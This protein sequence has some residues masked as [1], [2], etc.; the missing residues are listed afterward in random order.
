MRKQRAPL[1]D[2]FDRVGPFHPYLV[3]IGVAILDI[4][5]IAAA[6]ALLAMLGDAVEDAIWP[7]GFDVIQAL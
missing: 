5:I 1:P 4:F 6:F 3:W 7:G 2:G